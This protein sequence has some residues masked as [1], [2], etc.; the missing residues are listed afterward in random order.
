MFFHFSRFRSTRP[1]TDFQVH[2]ILHAERC[3]LVYRYGHVLARDPTGQEYYLG[4]REQIT[5]CTIQQYIT[6]LREAL[7]FRLR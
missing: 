5:T 4:Q 3:T 2:A 1:L 6:L 7:S